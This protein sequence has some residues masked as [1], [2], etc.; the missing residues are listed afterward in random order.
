MPTTWELDTLQLI[1]TNDTY[2]KVSGPYLGL[3]F[4]YTVRVDIG[5][6]HI[7]FRKL[8]LQHVPRES[9]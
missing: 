7:P 6:L 5:T 1:S 8:F 9:I 2:L 4:G 3:K